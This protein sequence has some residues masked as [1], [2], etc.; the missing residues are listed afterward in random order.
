MNFTDVDAE[1]KKI[2][3]ELSDPGKVA[4]AGVKVSGCTVPDVPFSTEKRKKAQKHTWHI[5]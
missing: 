3:A 5:I 1:L 4:L 2:T